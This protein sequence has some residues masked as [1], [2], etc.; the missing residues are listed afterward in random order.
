[1]ATVTSDDFAAIESTIKKTVD[2]IVSFIDSQSTKDFAKL[3][4]REKTI[5][6]GLVSRLSELPWTTDEGKVVLDLSKP[7]SIDEG[8]SRLFD[9]ID[10]QED[11]AKSDYGIRR[12]TQNKIGRVVALQI[13]Q[14]NTITAQSWR[15][16]LGA[17]N[18]PAKFS[19]VIVAEAKSLITTQREIQRNLRVILGKQ[20]RWS[21]YGKASN[22]FA[23]L[24]EA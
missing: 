18:N 14:V 21:T 24:S 8:V 2:R 3:T 4:L 5:R 10:A 1:M 16:V 20:F 12:F 6:K 7:G 17:L 11:A 9:F 15:T 23:L 13:R 22:V 19:P